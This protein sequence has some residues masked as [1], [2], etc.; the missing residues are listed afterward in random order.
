MISTEGIAEAT[1]QNLQRNPYF[2]PNV[3]FRMVD[4]N[5]SGIVS[6]DEIRYMME[7]RGHFISDAD[8]R[9]VTKKFDFNRDGVVTHNE[10]LESVRPKSPTRRMW[11]A[12]ICLLSNIHK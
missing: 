2:D 9:S 3:A 10:F 8:A 4:Y 11:I 6:K 12:D 5:D 1:R 7:S